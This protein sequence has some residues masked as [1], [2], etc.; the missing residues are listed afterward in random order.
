[1]NLYWNLKLK[2]KILRCDRNRHG[3]GAACYII[4]DLSY[5]IISVSPRESESVFFEI[6]LPN[7]K[8]ITVGT[9]Y[10]PQFI[11]FLEVLNENMNTIDSISNKIYIRG[12][13]NISFSL[14]DLYFLKKKC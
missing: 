12:D 3:G 1:M 6:L 8:T 2:Y 11:Q 13:F 7:S 5:N 10:C 4:N 9:I 14:N